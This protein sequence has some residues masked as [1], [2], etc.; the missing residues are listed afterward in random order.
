MPRRAL[1][2][3]VSDSVV[4]GTRDDRSGDVL[5]ARL[6]DLGYLVERRARRRRA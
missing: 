3:T 6:R 5:E 2:V 1:V 4:S